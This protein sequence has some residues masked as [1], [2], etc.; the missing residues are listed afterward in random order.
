MS[1]YEE[2]YAH[3][4]ACADGETESLVL[5][6]KGSA[7]VLK[8]GRWGLGAVPPEGQMELSPREEHTRRLLTSQ[9]HDLIR[10]LVSPY[11]Q[12]FAVASAVAAALA[13]SPR[14]GLPLESLL[15]LPGEGKVA[16]LTPDPWVIGFL[17]DWNWNVSIFD[18]VRRGMH[19]LPEWTASQHIA[20]SQWVW[21]TAEVFR[22]RTIFSLIP[23]LG[24]KGAILQGPGIP[25]LPAIYR[26]A[27]ITHLVLPLNSDE[28]FEDVLRYIAAGGTPWVC[29]SLPWSVFPLFEEG[30][31]S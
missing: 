17:K 25:F 6:W 13:P 19:V 28:N 8:D 1:L 2:I 21:F 29:P 9:A 23:F 24:K 7:V 20:S 15:P 31:L 12:E 18:D 27:G 10:L 11:P 5:G 30:A 4:L 14:K 16:L 22:R 26:K 3:L